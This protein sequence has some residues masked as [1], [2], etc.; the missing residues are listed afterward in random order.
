[1]LMCFKRSIL[2]FCLALAVECFTLGI[3]PSVFRR[4]VF[5]T[6]FALV[7]YDVVRSVCHLQDA[8]PD[9][10]VTIEQGSFNSGTTKWIA[11]GMRGWRDSMEDAH[12]ARELDPAIFGSAAL[13]AVLDGHGGCEV[14]NLAAA[15]LV[16][17]VESR[18]RA[19]G[20]S[21]SHLLQSI[22][23]ALP[24][25][26]QVLLRGLGGFGHVLPPPIH[27]FSTVGST[28]CV[29]GIDFKTMEVVCANIGDSRAILCKNGKAHAL[30]DD[31]KPEN[32]KEAARIRGAGGSVVKV[33]YCHRVDGNLNLSRAL[34]DFYLKMN[35]TLPP[36]KQK[37]IAFP[38]S[39]KFSF[40]GGKSE[41]LIIACDGL[42]EKKSSQE[43]VDLIWKRYKAGWDLDKIVIDVLRLCCARGHQGRPVEEGTDN[44]SL[45]L[46]E[47]PSAEDADQQNGAIKADKEGPITNPIAKQA[48]MKSG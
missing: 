40:T 6:A 37:V 32:Q 42:F 20:P 46:V 16:S 1:M 23:E 3:V 17:E 35:Y 44:E 47:L 12:V 28:A 45:I 36:D 8:G 4:Y 22:E 38:D 10:N 43:L 26:D 14:S 18:G 2:G 31:H 29:V 7:A 48:R 27:P 13:F 30:S 9:I 19:L 34:G 41:L 39:R 11:S 21:S 15:Q 24:K 5:Y 33:G 25:L